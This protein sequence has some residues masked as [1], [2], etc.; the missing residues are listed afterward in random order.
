MIMYIIIYYRLS[1]D[2]LGCDLW[3]KQKCDKLIDLSM[4]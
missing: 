4:F 3:G 2:S 1:N